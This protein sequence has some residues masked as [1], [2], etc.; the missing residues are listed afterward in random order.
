MVFS[1]DIGYLDYFYNGL[2]MS[3]VG[4]VKWQRMDN[5]CSME[6]YLHIDEYNG[7]S[8]KVFLQGTDRQIL[9][10]EIQVER[11]EASL[12]CFHLKADELHEGG[13]S[14]EDYNEIYIPLETGWYV[15]GKYRPSDNLRLQSIQSIPSQPS[16][17]Q[18]GA[19]RDVGEQ[20]E[21]VSEEKVPKAIVREDAS[22]EKVP[23]TMVREDVSEEN[24]PLAMMEED[25]FKKVPDE[26][27]TEET[28][29][30]QEKNEM[31]EVSDI[32]S[33]AS[34]EQ[35]MT[36][37][38]SEEEGMKTNPA[39]EVEKA[40]E[41]EKAEIE[42]KEEQIA[43]KVMKAKQ[44][45][46]EAIAEPT[47][48]IEREEKQDQA[49][50]RYR[51]RIGDLQQEEFGDTKWETLYKILPK[52]IPFQDERRFL[53]CML[54]DLICLSEKNFKF[55]KNPFLLYGYRQYGHLLLGRIGKGKSHNYLLGVPGVYHPQEIQAALNY[56]FESFEGIDK[57]QPEGQEGR[58]GYYFAKVS[59]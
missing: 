2:K 6:L 44:T 32:I 38:D 17:K 23:K 31:P 30:E 49:T 28:G 33:G 57:K 16:E 27:M 14:Y 47:E 20:R 5:D 40:K 12:K 35:D 59:L 42:E 9:F 58:Q 43:E 48:N 53:E 1:R 18:D 8:V 19:V 13:G 39:E 11:G 37:Q 56:G 45:E 26:N 41:E 55:C 22:E 15:S 25:V 7:D 3:T 50:E 29:S 24:T 21:D 51:S 46:K 36:I 54:E 10:R 52:R 4:M 34:R